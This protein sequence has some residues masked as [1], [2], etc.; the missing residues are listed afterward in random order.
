MAMDLVREVDLLFWTAANVLTAILAVTTIAKKFDKKLDPSQRKANLV[1]GLYFTCMMIA[2]T[3]NIVWRLYVFEIYGADMAKFI[4][5]LSMIVLNIGWIILISY[6][7]TT[8]KWFKRPYFLYLMIG[9]L[10]FNLLVGYTHGTIIEIIYA[11]LTGIGFSL[12]PIIFLI[13]ARRSEGIIRKNSYLIFLGSLIFGIAMTIQRQNV[14]SFVP[15][16]VEFFDNFIFPFVILSPILIIISNVLMF[17]GIWV[18][19]SLNAQ[20]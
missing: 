19:Y 13:I 8:M 4:E 6:F 10:I 16:V 1:W 7:D 15:S 5:R 11:A 2:N 12:F 3:L 18:I 17:I 14:I 9:L 20:V